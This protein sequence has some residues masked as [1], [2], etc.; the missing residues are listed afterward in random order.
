MDEGRGTGGVLERFPAGFGGSGAGPG[1]ATNP[2]PIPHGGGGEGVRLRRPVIGLGD[3]RTGKTWG[4]EKA[5]GW[6]AEVWLVKGPL[7]IRFQS[8]HP[9]TPPPKGSVICV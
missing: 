3:N 4:L 8:I 1:S 2:P 7:P 6:G 9:P 5:I